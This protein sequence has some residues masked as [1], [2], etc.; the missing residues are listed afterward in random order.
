RFCHILRARITCDGERFSVLLDHAKAGFR[1]ECVA[2]N[3]LHVLS[4]LTGIAMLVAARQTKAKTPSGTGAANGRGSRARKARSR[5]ARTDG[6]R[7]RPEAWL[8]D[9]DASLCA[10][11]RDGPRLRLREGWEAECGQSHCD[12][13]CSHLM[14]TPDRVRFWFA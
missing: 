8:V 1:C 2:S 10:G 4:V 6:R 3:R 11:L 14:F 12:N 7:D 13:K 5:Q 9:V